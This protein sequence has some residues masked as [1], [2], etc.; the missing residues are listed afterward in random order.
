MIQR[1][2]HAKEQGIRQTVARLAERAKKKKAKKKRLKSIP[3]EEEQV[4]RPAVSD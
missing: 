2:A 4:E 3:G 1:Y